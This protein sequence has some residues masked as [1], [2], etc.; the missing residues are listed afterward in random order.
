MPYM[1]TIRDVGLQ[2]IAEILLNFVNT[3]NQALPG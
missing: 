1:F 2:K 3:N